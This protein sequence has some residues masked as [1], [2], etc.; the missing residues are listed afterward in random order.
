MATDAQWCFGIVVSSIVQKG[1]FFIDRGNVD[2]EVRMEAGVAEIG[3]GGGHHW[4]VIEI[5]CSMLREA[6]GG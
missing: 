3:F 6:G 5:E 2:G 4:L 1:G